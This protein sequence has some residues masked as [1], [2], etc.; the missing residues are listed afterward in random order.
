MAKSNALTIATAVDVI[1]SQ[2]REFDFT[3][4]GTRTTIGID[5]LTP[6][7]LLPVAPVVRAKPLSY[8]SVS[9]LNPLRMPIP[10]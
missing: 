2:E 1:Q 4:A 10:I 9:C 8:P 5:H 7:L 3:T 6:S